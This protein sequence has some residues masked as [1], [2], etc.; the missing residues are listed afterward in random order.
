MAVDTPPFFSDAQD[1]P[2]P[3]THDELPASAWTGIAGTFHR[4][5]DKDFFAGEFPIQC[6][7]GS[8]V[9]GTS[10][11]GLRAQLV[12]QIPDLDGWPSER[13]QPSTVTAMDVVVFGWKYVQQP[14][15]RHHHRFPDHHHYNF[16]R[17]AGRDLWRN[18]INGILSRNGVSLRQESDGSV[19]RVGSAAAGLATRSPVPLTGNGPLDEK[20]ATALRKYADAD[21][22]VRLEALEALWDAL[23][24]VKT[25][26]DPTDKKR[27]ATELVER[28]AAAPASRDLLAAEFRAVT[29]IGNDFQI[30]HHEV[31]KCPVEAVM[32]DLLFTRC[33]TLVE[34]A[35]RAVAPPQ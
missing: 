17:K 5:M 4:F 27:S 8:A 21:L 13:N 34:A 1:G 22:V 24:R 19:V 16:D 26:I 9:V 32:V 28:M 11:G 14:N 10:S 6:E 15:P 18:E 7:D 20:L 3:L 31:S 35:V 30:R 23:E 29:A 33:L 12:G 25:V 2:R